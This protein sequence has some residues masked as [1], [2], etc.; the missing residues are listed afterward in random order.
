MGWLSSRPWFSGW[1]WSTSA[2]ISQRDEHAS[3]PTGRVLL[4]L[5][6]G[7]QWLLWKNWPQCQRLLG[8]V[9]REVP[10]RESLTSGD[11]KD[12]V[13]CVFRDDTDRGLGD[14]SFPG[15]NPRGKVDM[16]RFL[17]KA[18]QKKSKREW[19]ILFLEKPLIKIGTNC[20]ILGA[21]Q[22]TSQLGVCLIWEVVSLSEDRSRS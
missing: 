19:I 5:P 18:K 9:P 6:E 10:G 21:E 12:S 4:S 16:H 14:H 7:R 11:L 1:S 17:E 3:L 20:S 13:A 15:A 8:L 22:E 2:W